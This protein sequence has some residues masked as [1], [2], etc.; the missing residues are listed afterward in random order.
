MNTIGIIAAME[1][2]IAFI[3]SIMEV[4][5]A[6]SV[7]TMEFYV[8]KIGGKSVVTVRS[9]IGKVN[10]AL[11]AQILIDLFAVDY[12]INIGTAGAICPEVRVG[13]IIISSDVCQHDVN[14]EAFGYKPG[15]IPRMKESFFKADQELV[16]LA[17]SCAE[18]LP[19]QNRVFVGR[20]ASGDQFIA[21][22][23]RKLWIW[24][25]FKAY[26]AEMEGAAIAHA[27]ALNNLPFIIIRQVS[28][29]ADDKANISFDEFIK[30]YMKS[31]GV[32]VEKLVQAL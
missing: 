16:D 5:A 23:A 2:E 15:V 11:S 19:E 30:I 12:I 1:E 6:K 29:Q 26:C 20:I 25:E 10:A 21:D 24:S 4:K 13:D 28:D 14:A 7:A 8:G 17:S 3:K 31:Y 9:G 22:S 18:T 32:L 27:C